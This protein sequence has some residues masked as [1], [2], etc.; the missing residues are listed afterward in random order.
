MNMMNRQMMEI[1]YDAKKMPL[2]KLSEDNIRHGYKILKKLDKAIKD[3]DKTLI[4]DLNDEFFSY[5]PHDFGFQRMEFFLIDT[6]VKLKKKLDMLESLTDIKVATRLIGDG[7][8]DANRYDEHYAKLNRDI[9]PIKD[10]SK[11]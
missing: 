8:S 7:K 5:I 11:E 9:H 4:F 10:S 3:R 1:G 6:D 2:G